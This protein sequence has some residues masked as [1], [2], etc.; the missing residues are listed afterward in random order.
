MGREEARAK[1]WNTF[2]Q[3][4][5]E[6]AKA[7]PKFSIQEFELQRLDSCYRSWRDARD[8]ERFH[9]FKKARR[10]YTKSVESLEQFEKLENIPELT[11]ML[12]RLKADY[13][14]FVFYRDPEY[15]ETLKYI[16]PAIQKFDGILQTEL[17]KFEKP[18]C[19]RD[20][21]TYALYFAEKEGLVRRE[22]KGR[23]YQLY[24]LKGKDDS[25][26][27]VIQDDEIDAQREA[28]NREGCAVIVGFFLWICAL[29]VSGLFAGP[30][31]VVIIIVA[32]VVRQ[33][34]KRN[35]KKKEHAAVEPLA[36]PE[37]PNE[38]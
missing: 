37:K 19:K 9:D 16:L 33:I 6:H 11:A 35:K 14:A 1:S 23:S 2:R 28:E 25:A 30:V 32:F 27:Q 17:Y 13:T 18:N 15:R 10:L 29:L 36:L 21:M 20:D 24:F 3:R 7:D 26:L 12:N 31:G 22:K 4:I 5:Y 8:A 34:V 38:Q